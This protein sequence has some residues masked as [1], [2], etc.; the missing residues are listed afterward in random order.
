MYFIPYLIFFVS[1]IFSLKKLFKNTESSNVAQF[2]DDGTR[3][4]NKTKV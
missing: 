1:A 2:V 3:T 4:K